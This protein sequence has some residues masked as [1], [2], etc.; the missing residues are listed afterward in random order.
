MV[1]SVGRCYTNPLDYAQENY[2]TMGESFT[3]A[4]WLGKAAQVQGLS[5]Q[6]KEPDFLNAYSSLDPEGNP[7]R[8][9][10]QYKKSSHRYNRPGTDVTLSAPKSVS[11]AA[12]V[13]QDPKILEAHKAAVRATMKY[14]ENNC[15]F[16]QT[17]QRGKKQLLQSET[18]QIAVFHHDDNRN[19]DPQLHSHCVIL[20]QTVCPDGKWRAVANEQLYKQ[21]KTIGAYYDHELARQI[22]QL[23]YQVEWTSDHTFELA[24]IDKEK[25]DAVFST[26]SNQI[27]AEL[28]KLGLTRSSATAEQKQAVCLKTRQEKKQHHHPQDRIKQLEEWQTRARESGIEISKPTEYHREFMKRTYHNPSYF[29]NFKNLISNATENLTEH[30]SAFK[31]H[32]LLRECLRQSQ[33]RYD[34][35]KILSEIALHKEFVPTRDQRL[36]TKSVLSRE[37]KIIQLAKGGINSQIPLSSQEKAEAVS[38]SRSL[39]QGQATALKQMVTSRDS[40]ILIQGNAGVGKTYTMKALASTV[41]DKQPIR[42]LAPSAAAASV[43]QDESG[44]TSQ[45]LAS[46]LLTPK[47]QLPQQ[48]VILVDEAGMISTRSA[49]QLLEKAHEL[50]SRVILIGDTKQLSAISAGAPFKLLQD[51][52]LPIATIDQNLRQRDPNLKQVVNSLATHDKNPDSVNGAYQKLNE[53]EKIKQIV[54]DEKRIDTIA[55]DYL[56]RPVEIRR[57]TLILAGTNAD[58]KAIASKVRQGLIAEGTLGDE[59]LKIQ[60]LRRKNIDKFALTQA[61]NYQRGDVIKFQTDSAKFSKDLYYRV[62]SVN[63]Q[64]Q[65]ATLIDTVGITETLEL[66]KY[67][68]REVYLLQQ[69]EI[70]PGELL[71]F[72]K[73]I[74]NS[75]YKQLNG[76]RFTVSSITEDG[77]ITISSNGKTQDISIERLLHSDYS[78]VDTV[79]SSQ[80]LTADY[81]IYSAA[82]AKSMTI[83]RESFYV[84]ASRAR[85]EFVV[86]TANTQD[87]GVTVQISRANENAKDL[88]N[89][90]VVKEKVV[91]NAKS[92]QISQTANPSLPSTEQESSHSSNELNE[93]AGR[94][95]PES[96]QRRSG[97]DKII[98]S[99]TNSSRRAE[100]LATNLQLPRRKAQTTGRDTSDLNREAEKSGNNITESNRAAAELTRELQELEQRAIGSDIKNRKTRKPIFSN[101]NRNSEKNQQSAKNIGTD[102]KN[103]LPRQVRSEPYL[104]RSNEN[105]PSRTNQGKRNYAAD[106]H[107]GDLGTK[108]YKPS[109]QQNTSTNQGQGQQQRNPS[110][111]YR[112]EILET[113]TVVPTDLSLEMRSLAGSEINQSAPKNIVE[114]VEQLLSSSA[115]QPLSQDEVNQITLTALSAINRYGI[116][117]NSKTTFKNKYYQIE[118]FSVSNNYGGSSYLTI[119]ALD[120]RGRVLTLLGENSH[121]ANLKIQENHL[122]KKD[123]S[124][125]EKIQSALDYLQQVRQFKDNAQIIVFK[126]GK[127]DW[128]QS[129]KG[130]R[131]ILE[132]DKYRIERDDEV[133]RVIAKDGRGE[134]LNYPSNPNARHPE[135]QAKAKFNQEDVELF[136]TIVQQIE[137]KRR[138]AERTRLLEQS[139]QR[140]R[141]RGLSR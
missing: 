102:S 119:D 53:Q 11:V 85:Q 58:K 86:Y 76:Q 13:Y 92:K 22:Q 96:N 62:T 139:Q 18:A 21:Q 36:T 88:V 34:P 49:R 134:I 9:Q 94:S 103:N 81:C 38:K 123:L 112:G 84:A 48:E 137:Q 70:R 122:T 25:L 3:N 10:Q 130:Y 77:Q 57:K 106:Y 74:R 15:I 29:N 75:D 1:A 51:A 100:E 104:V 23:G 67:K 107:S 66:N 133:L 124:T 14:V 120:G 65:T 110:Q 41:G 64:N 68:Q 35:E 93:R 40:V 59:N 116:E 69:L 98:D 136:S 140:Q 73:N 44:I 2:Y 79:H 126:Y 55:S 108:P 132:G 27:E 83:G 95:E 87:L 131:R 63:P 99:L 12:L 129:H 45:T 47:E 127:R 17:K 61:H 91:D 4:E 90:A 26:R 109:Q 39:N 33:G 141:G 80:G 50:K 28:A 138:E 52:G 20:N 7:L 24:G 128:Q 97:L 121:L 125:F 89:S 5:G 56:S 30:S 46:Y 42:G 31:P 111:T 60:T 54:E 115:P 135:T 118:K 37:Q 19:K 105:Q 114:E 43:L 8:K 72:T 117:E 82:N 71:R 16:Y 6:I 101:Q 78:Y 32:E 113:D